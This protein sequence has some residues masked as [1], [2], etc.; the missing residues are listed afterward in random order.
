MEIQGSSKTTHPS[1]IAL[2]VDDDDSQALLTRLLL[3][4][5][6][7]EVVLCSNPFDALNLFRTGNANFHFVATDY[8]MFPMDGLELAKNILSIAPDTAIL[9][10]TGLDHPAIFRQARDLGVREICTKPTTADEFAEVL[11]QAGL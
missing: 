4:R 11:L 5:L 8:A 1:G 7:Y 3:E 9:L 10:L 2:I 6:G